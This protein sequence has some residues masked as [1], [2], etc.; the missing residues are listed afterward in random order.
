[1][2]TEEK[3][4]EFMDGRSLWTQKFIRVGALEVISWKNRLVGCLSLRR[5]KCKFWRLLSYLQ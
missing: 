2:N 4:V 5:L 3:V 1:M